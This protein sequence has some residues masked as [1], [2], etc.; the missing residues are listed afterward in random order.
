MNN[1]YLRGG[2]IYYEDK[3]INYLGSCENFVFIFIYR[4]IYV[5]LVEFKEIINIFII[6][7]EGLN[8]FFLI[9]DKKDIK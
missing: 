1:Y 6:I 3:I 4:R 2:W 8:I 7:V 9:I 5:R